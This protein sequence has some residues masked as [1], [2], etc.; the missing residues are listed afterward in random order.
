MKL[1][2][3]EDDPRIATNL[4]RG[5]VSE[6]YTVDLVLDGDSGLDYSSTHP[7][8]AII[9]DYMLPRRSG[10][11]LCKE[12]RK[13]KNFTPILMLTAK[14][15]K[16]D[17]VACLDAGADDYLTKPFSF[18]ELLAR[19]RALT[20]RP[21]TQTSD[22]LTLG[23]LSLD[24]KNYSVVRLQRQL[25]LSQKEFA[26]LAYL[27]RHPGVPVSK[28]KIID[29][30]W[31]FDADILPNTVEVYIR[32]LREKIDIPFRPAL[33]HIHTIRGFGYMVK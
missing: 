24:P 30:V 21:V 4:Q 15:Q 19:I 1:L 23:D 8:D 7:Y 31:N 10:L 16:E 20:R 12:I 27:M 22:I 18:E 14:N 33:S 25:N 26:L 29:A 3:V 6:R 32:K 2:L 17:I 9:L 11:E 5:L 28:D 13:M